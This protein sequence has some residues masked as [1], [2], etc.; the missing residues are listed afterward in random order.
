MTRSS[1]L[2]IFL[3]LGGNSEGGSYLRNP[4]GQT[5]N[6][7]Q[8]STGSVSKKPFLL[9]QEEKCTV[10]IKSRTAVVTYDGISFEENTSK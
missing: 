8:S 4:K 7:F 10:C 2:F 3:T 9:M 5:C 1:K 6:S